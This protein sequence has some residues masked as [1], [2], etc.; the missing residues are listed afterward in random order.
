[1]AIVLRATEQ[2]GRLPELLSE[3]IG[4]PVAVIHASGTANAATAAKAATS[5]IPIVFANGGDP[6]SL[7]LVASLNRPTGNITGVTWGSGALT[8]KRLE[9][10]RE[11]LPQATLI[12]FLVNPTSDRAEADVRD[13]ETA[14]RNIGQE[15]TVVRASNPEEIDSAFAIMAERHVGALLVN[16]DAFFT[17]RPDQIV[18]LAARYR[19]PASYPSRVSVDVGGLISYGDDRAES[20]RQAGIYVGRILKGEKPADLPVLQPAKFEFV[21]N[22]KTAKALGITF[23]PSFHLRADEVIE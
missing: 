6:V 1:V 13:M 16:G 7:G 4:L 21:I 17:R 22:L 10:L 14:A 12:A 18:A 3:L 8:L 15:I 19:F 23:P 2:Y 9:L 20:N 11:L 5:T